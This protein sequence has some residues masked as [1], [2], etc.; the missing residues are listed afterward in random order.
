MTGIKSKKERRILNYLYKDNTNLEIIDN[1][2]PD[3]KLKHKDEK[4][5]FGVEV[6]E[7]YFTESSARLQNIPDYIGDLL[8]EKKYRHKDDKKELEIK[9]VSIISKN[10]QKKGEP[11]A[12]IYKIPGLSYYQKKITQIIRNKNQKYG[13]YDKTLTHIN[14]IIYDEE[15]FLFSIKLKNFYKMFFSE[16]LIKSIIASEFR[17]IY[18]ITTIEKD[19]RLYFP[20]KMI[21]FLSRIYIFSYYFTNFYP[22]HSELSEDESLDFFIEYL[23]YK[24][25]SGLKTQRYKQKLEILYGNVGFY[26]EE[27]NK[28]TLKNYQDYELPSEAK[29]INIKKY[30]YIN[31]HFKREIKKV[32]SHL[33]FETEV[34]FK[35]KE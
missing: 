24:G 28:I 13:D 33:A 20:L 23:D 9:K 32:H 22:R 30:N 35:I 16:D 14:L 4:S 1:D 26:L 6:T 10:G 34:G 21:L 15:K 5:Y 11:E 17:E 7:F 2:K 12:I 27:G 18:F 29:T 8:D 19:K 3:F 25:F 31:E